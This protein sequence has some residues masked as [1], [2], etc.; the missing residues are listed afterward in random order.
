MRVI[1]VISTFAF[2]IFLC[3]CVQEEDPA[4]TIR[5][6]NINE[7]TAKEQFTYLEE[8]TE[9]KREAYNRFLESGSIANLTNFTPEEMVLIHMNLVMNQE[10]EKIYKITYNGGKID[11]STKFVEQYI[12]TVS[13]QFEIDYLMY[14]YY[15]SISVVEDTSNEEMKIVEMKISLGSSTYAITFA[16]LREDGIWKMDYYHLIESKL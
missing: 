11:D 9:E 3:G 4:E 2:M 10:L 12:E 8:L 6:Y 15:D 13:S 1:K 5:E 7:A 16:M 14:R